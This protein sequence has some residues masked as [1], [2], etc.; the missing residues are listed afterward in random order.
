MAYG[1]FPGIF[2]KGAVFQAG[3]EKF[4]ENL[5]KPCEKFPQ[6]SRKIRGKIRCK[7]RSKIRGT[8]RDKI[9]CK[10]DGTKQPRKQAPNSKVKV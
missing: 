6:N 3:C 8:I 10:I 4:A 2:C 7:I 9:H 1:N 5:W